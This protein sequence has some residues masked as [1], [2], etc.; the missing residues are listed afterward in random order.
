M[1]K[2]TDDSQVTIREIYTLLDKNRDEI[3]APILRLET[4]FDNLESGRLAN[5]ENRM[6]SI[7]SELSNL[8]GKTMMIPV[9]ISAAISIFSLVINIVVGSFK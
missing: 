1:A 9:L 8:Q 4:K 3:M 7:R 6:S 5:L 2:R